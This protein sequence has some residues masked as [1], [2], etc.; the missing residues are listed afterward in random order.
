MP[1]VQPIELN[2][3]ELQAYFIIYLFWY[4]S[5]IG[6]RKKE[7]KGSFIL[8]LPSLK[9]TFGAFSWNCLIRVSPTGAAPTLMWMRGSRWCGLM[10]GLWAQY[11]TRGGAKWSVS[12][13]KRAYPVI[14]VCNQEKLNTKWAI[15]LLCLML[16]KVCSGGTSAS[17]L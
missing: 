10:S 3:N 8:Y 15:F 1:G 16:C 5:R 11:W 6:E 12:G 13:W 14:L 7:R 4:R 9:R 17:N 2:F